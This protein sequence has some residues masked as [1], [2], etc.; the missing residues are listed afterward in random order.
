MRMCLAISHAA[1][2]SVA[3]PFVAPAVSTASS[4][5]CN[6]VGAVGDGLRQATH[7][8]SVSE[9]FTHFSRFGVGR[10]RLAGLRWVALSL[11]T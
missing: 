2:H 3:A 1:A 6:R 10:V 5:D 8:L 7:F 11:R 9:Q 4:T